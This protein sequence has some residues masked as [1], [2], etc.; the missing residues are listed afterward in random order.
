MTIRN[1]QDAYRDFAVQQLAGEVL[2]GNLADG[3]NAAIECCDRFVGA[4]RPALNWIS[5]DFTEEKSVTFEQLR[6]HSSRF[7]NWLRARGIGRG[8]VVAG[9]LP[10]IPELLTVA[11]GSWRVGAIY[12]PLFTAFGPAAIA[13]R[14]TAAGGSQAK[15]IVTDETN[16]PK[17]DELE[18]CPPVQLVG[19]DFS[20]ALAAQPAECAPVMLCGEDPFVILFT[21]GTTGNPKAVRWPLRMLLNI[22]IYMR[23]AIGLRPED[24][25]WNVADPGWAYGMAFSA[26]GP[27]QLG[28]ATTFFEGGFSVESA[29]RVIVSH[30][31]T[32]IA[33]APTVY[34]LMMAAGDA[35]E[36]IAGRLRVASSAGEPLNPEVVRWAE[37]VL[38][39][40]LR[41]HYGQ[42]E[43]LMTVN[44]HHALRHS[45]RPGAA[46]LAMPGFSV[47]VLDEDLRPVPPDTPGVLA[48]HRPTSPL[49][50]FDGYWGADTP[51]FR[52][53]WYL[54]GD[55]VQQDADGHI[56]FVGRNDDIITSASYRIGP[57]DVES[58]IIEHPSV[59]EV[60]VVGKPDP[61]R[62][63]I[64]KAFVV[65]RPGFAAS[66]ALKAE[67]QQHVRT[68][69]GL[70]AYPR[71]IEFIT[72]LPKTP[73]GKVQ[74]FLLRR[75]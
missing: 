2:S 38:R 28:L 41:D 48:L 53:D 7:A 54:T 4:N 37:R 68:R 44:N 43:T 29:L 35:L 30:H 15:L 31:I 52:G 70:H 60:A 9:L 73:S 57:F 51:S 20:A 24:H 18:N 12:Q 5:K 75:R 63:E 47:A 23:D 72:E 46:G 69:L 56:F 3:T 49:F 21:S 45:V 58:S 11:F 59:A 16:R 34:R 36:P 1:Y 10:R 71:E 27:L 55:T 26:I 19:D 6:D 40:P 61:E 25:F 13:S 42:T 64:V 22:A 17:L 39:V 50:A 32:N 14:V 33:A 8:D 67:L 65:L 66:E 62:T 74:R